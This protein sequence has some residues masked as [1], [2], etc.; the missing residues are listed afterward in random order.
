MKMKKSFL[1]GL[2]LFLSVGLVACGNNNN[3]E[4]TYVPQVE[5]PTDEIEDEQDDEIVEAE[6]H[7]SSWG[8]ITT[9]DDLREALSADS[10]NRA[11]VAGLGSDLVVEGPLVIDGYAQ[12]HSGG[13]W[14]ENAD[15]SPVHSRKIGF[16]RRDVVN[17]IPRTPV[18]TFSLTVTEG[19]VVNSPQTFFI[20]DGPYIANVHANIEVNIPYFR[21][22]GVRVFGDITFANE[23]YFETAVFQLW[24]SEIAYV[25]EGDDEDYETDH[26]LY[27]SNTGYQGHNDRVAIVSSADASSNVSNVD[28]AYLV[29][30]NIYIAGNE[31]PV[32]EGP[33]YATSR[34]GTT[35]SA[36]L[37]ER[38]G[39]TS[40]NRAWVVGLASDITLDEQLVIEGNVLRHSGGRFTGTYAR[41][42]GFYI[43]AE[44]G[45]V[46]R[47]PVG[48]HTL[49]A[50]YGIVVNSPNTFFISEG[51]FIAEVHGDVYVNIPYFR[52][53]GVRIHGNVIFAN[54]HYRDTAIAQIWDSEVANIVSD[55]D[56]LYDDA[57]HGE[58]VLYQGNSGFGVIDSVAGHLNESNVDFSYLV[59]GEIR[60]AE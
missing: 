3:N 53:S 43:R 17:G 49:Y 59:T 28:P 23:Y 41:K 34:G 2:S 54:E 22:S 55:H 38:L 36:D 4:E 35:T 6:G 44:I 32:V 56:G 7:A 46:P 11:W 60:I 9:A 10:P 18:G 25:H 31:E 33:G 8:G 48:A 50:P 47:I 19:I 15:G 14:T 20:S 16:Y 26:V 21:L 30:G 58:V 57:E 27:H 51:P 29:A 24:D 40:E 52:L 42:L 37:V 12:R 1:V 45:G 5:E 13:A 39:A